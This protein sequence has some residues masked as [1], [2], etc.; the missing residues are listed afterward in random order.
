LNTFVFAQAGNVLIDQSF[1]S[2]W[3]TR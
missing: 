3:E 2:E 1:H